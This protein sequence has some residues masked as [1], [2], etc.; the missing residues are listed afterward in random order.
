MTNSHKAHT[1]T[2]IGNA[3]RDEQDLEAIKTCT[4]CGRMYVFHVEKTSCPDCDDG[5]LYPLTRYLPAETDEQDQQ[6]GEA[7]AGP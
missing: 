4:K 1:A 6:N 7:Y 5:R 3:L 2:K